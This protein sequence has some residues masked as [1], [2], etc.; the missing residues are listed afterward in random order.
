[1]TKDEFVKDI[2]QGWIKTDVQNMMNTKP[3]DFGFGA[4]N[5]P[6]TFM[7]LSSIDA[8][9]TFLLGK[10]PRNF[11]LS[12]STYINLCLPQYFEILN[13]KFLGDLVR[14]GLAHEYFSRISVTKNVS[15]D[16]IYKI[17]ESE[18]AINSYKLGSIFINS[19]T[20]FSEILPDHTFESRYNE[21]Q[22]RFQ[23][24]KNENKEFINY[25]K[26]IDTDKNKFYN[27]LASSINGPIKN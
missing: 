27:S 5:Y 11:Q 12:T 13:T 1:M 22:K 19:L 17:T 15:D 23:E 14:N 25:L 20:K 10:D 24:F 3:N 6:L 21:I 26:Y 8:L 7:V 16:L 18:I 4:L 9:G 2:V